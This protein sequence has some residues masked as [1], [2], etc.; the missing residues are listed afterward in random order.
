M[1][2]P[3]PGHAGPVRWEDLDR[4]VHEPARLAILVQLA[5]VEEA[6]FLYLMR[7]TGL[8][9]GNLSSHLSKLEGAGY[10]RITKGFVGRIPQ[11]RLSLTATG[12]SAFEEYRARLAVLLAEPRP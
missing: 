6:D 5:F 4:V 7:Q 9:R 10:L 8:T 12:R 2:K 1:K 3:D 11:T